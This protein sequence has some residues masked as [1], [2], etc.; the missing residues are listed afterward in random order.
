MDGAPSALV[1]LMPM[2]E[3]PYSKDNATE[4]CHASQSGMMS[5]LSTATAGAVMCKSSAAVS[6]ART[7]AWETQ[8]ATDSTANGADY[9]PR[10]AESLARFNPATSSWKTRQQSLFGGLADYSETWPEWGMMQDGECWALKM[11]AALM[12]AVGSGSLPTPCA[13]DWKGGTTQPQKRNGKLRTHQY[14]HWC[15]ILHG[16]TYPIPEHMEAMMGWPI[17]WSALKPLETANLR[18]WCASHGTSWGPENQN[19]PTWCSNEKADLPPTEARQPRSGTE[20][21]NGG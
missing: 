9:G 12:P 20:T 8:T 21:T 2:P 17:G 7:S 1:K 16:L 11:P 18:Q 4:Y 14:K 19:A 15:K 3:M 6:H 10:C 13:S 5:K